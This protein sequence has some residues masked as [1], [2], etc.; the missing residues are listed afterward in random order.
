MSL[1]FCCALGQRPT[2]HKKSRFF[3]KCSLPLLHISPTIQYQPAVP[4]A[5]R[6]HLLQTIMN[7]SHLLA[8]TTDRVSISEITLSADVRP[9]T[10]GLGVRWTSMNV[11]HRHVKMEEHVWTRW[12]FL[13]SMLFVIFLHSPALT[14]RLTPSVANGDLEG[15]WTRDNTGVAK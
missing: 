11:S 14:R 8:S 6:F 3:S 1:Q 13:L 12:V 10:L 5:K 9:V 2:L 7:V 15:T 4:V